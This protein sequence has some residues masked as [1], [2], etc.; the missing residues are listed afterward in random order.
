M[1]V[2]PAAYRRNGTFDASIF[3]NGG[4]CAQL[5]PV[6][7]FMAVEPSKAVP[8]P[9]P[10]DVWN[11]SC[12]GG[13]TGGNYLGSVG[14]VAEYTWLLYRPGGPIVSEESRSEMLNFTPPGTH[15]FSFYGMGTFNLSWSVGD[16]LGY[17]HVGDTYGYQ[18]QVGTRRRERE[19]KR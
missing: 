12:A 5:T 19:R 16:A 17:G 18:S 15:R 3:T 14:D 2:I 4:A 9:P 8:S 6:H 7:G 11:V 10:V 13:W 1:S